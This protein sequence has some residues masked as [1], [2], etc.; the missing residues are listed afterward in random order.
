MAGD[1]F[2]GD[3]VAGDKFTGNKTTGDTITA[4][5]GAGAKN[6]AVGKDIRQTITE[7]YGPPTPDDKPA[8]EAQL[9]RVMDALNA[10]TTIDRRKAGRAEGELAALQEEL[11]KTGADETPNAT[12]ITR[13]GDWLLNN[14]PEIGQALTELFGMP[15]VGRGAAQ[16]RGRGG[17]L[18]QA[19]ASE[20]SALALM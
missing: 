2:T 6:V 11:T 3:K 1:K 10:A 20:M 13:V 5:I 15:A 14:V 9:Q 7:N 12:T 17:G 4:T 19:A 18:G 16:G 8:I